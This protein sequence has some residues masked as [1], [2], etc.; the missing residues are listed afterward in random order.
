MELPILEIEHLSHRYNIQWAIRDVNFRISRKGIY[1]LLGSNGAGKSTTMNIMC[2]V[3]KQTDGLVKI[4]GLETLKQGKEAK[5]KIGFLPQNPPLYGDLT[6]EEYLELCAHLHYIPKEDI[7]KAIGKVLEQCSIAHFRKRLIKSL[8][9]GYRQR[10][11][12]AQAIIHKPEVVILDEPTNGL[13]P[14]QIIDIRYLI[15]QISEDSTV[16]LSTHIL[17]EVQAM[18]DHIIMIEQGK[19]VFNDTLERFDNYIQPYNLLV[20]FMNPPSHESL[21]SIP[22][23]MNLDELAANRFRLSYKDVREVTDELLRRSAE[24]DWR[25]MEVRVERSSL[26]VIFKELSTRKDKEIYV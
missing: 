22:G 5:M 12:I 10:V 7:K 17:Q 8:S 16:I 1:G 14:N 6:V 20:S 2:G 24:F 21:R 15:K 3:I 19:V 4:H 18:C 25:P 23:V 11:G 13:D 26:E 9:G